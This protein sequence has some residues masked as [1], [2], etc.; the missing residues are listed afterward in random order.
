MADG[1]AEGTATGE[2]PG[3]GGQLVLLVDLERRSLTT[4]REKPVKIGAKAVRHGRYVTIRLAEVAVPRH[5]FREIPRR[6]DELRP[7][8]TPA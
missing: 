1:V 5:L 3:S 2:V 7:S 8:P 4:L 6:I